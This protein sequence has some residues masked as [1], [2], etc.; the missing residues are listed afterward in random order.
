MNPAVILAVLQ[1]SGC[2]AAELLPGPLPV[3][4]YGLHIRD[5]ETLREEYR[6]LGGKV[7]RIYGFATN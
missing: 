4:D 7:Q 1:L 3:G 2:V 5:S 6:E